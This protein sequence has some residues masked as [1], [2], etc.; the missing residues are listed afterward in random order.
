MKVIHLTE[1]AKSIFKV[2][3]FYPT[4]ASLVSEEVG[5]HHRHRLKCV[6]EMDP[7]TRHCWIHAFTLNQSPSCLKL[8]TVNPQ[9]ELSL[10]GSSQSHSRLRAGVAL[11]HLGTEQCGLQAVHLLRVASGA[12]AD[13]GCGFDFKIVLATWKLLKSPLNTFTSV[14]YPTLAP[15]GSLALSL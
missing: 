8:R 1:E 9:A 11:V 3:A 10:Q 13:I 14:R 7:F 2:P 5:L 12:T 15:W 6:R 4:R